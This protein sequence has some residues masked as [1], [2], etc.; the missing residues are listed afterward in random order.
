MTQNEVFN[1]LQRGGAYTLPYLIR[2]YH[3]QYGALYFVNNNESV[4]YN[5]TVYEASTFKYTRPQ[6]VGGVLKNGALEITAIDNEV[7]DI[8]DESDELFEV[9]AVGVIDV[10]GSITPIN[11]FKHIYGTVTTDEEMKVVIN[12]TNDDRLEMSFPP[13]VFDADNNPG[14]A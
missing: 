5:N 13:Y 2:L 12:F 1:A 11:L 6:T 7:I 9:T 8:I 10:D 4:T 3:P 14:N